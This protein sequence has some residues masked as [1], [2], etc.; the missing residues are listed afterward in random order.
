M[1]DVGV[2]DAKLGGEDEDLK[3][4][5]EEERERTEGPIVVLN[6]SA[7]VISAE[8][9]VPML[10]ATACWSKEIKAEEVDNGAEETLITGTGRIFLAEALLPLVL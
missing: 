4:N 8:A 6:P 2:V 5:A 9:D 1:E 10:V 3:R 7:F